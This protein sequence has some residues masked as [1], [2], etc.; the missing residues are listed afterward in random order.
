MAGKFHLSDTG[1]FVHV[2]NPKQND[3]KEPKRI[4]ELVR[5]LLWRRG[6][7]IE[8]D[9]HTKKHY[10]IL[11]RDGN[12]R[13]GRKGD[14]EFQADFY[15]IGMKIEF[16]QNVVFEN[17]NGGRYDY[18]KLKRMPYLLRL[19]FIANK[20]AI[21]KLL[22]E[23]GFVDDTDEVPET[24][25]DRVIHNNKRCWHAR[26][27]GILVWGLNASRSN[28]TDRDG[29]VIIP[30]QVKCFYDRHGTLRKGVAYYGLNLFLL[31]DAFFF[32]DENEAHL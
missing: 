12:H 11:C 2:A 26:G 5:G 24:A 15:P 17:K 20:N 7:K 18:G 29:K 19:Q 1:I 22:V 13:Y 23:Q 32:G 30:G 16:F 8:A 28:I 21:C 31:P 10:R 27:C 14:L 9:P 4:F 3:T 25:I 6:F